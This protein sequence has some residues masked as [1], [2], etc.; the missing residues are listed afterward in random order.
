M[1]N[2]LRIAFT[3]TLV[4]V[5]S[6]GPHAQAQSAKATLPGTDIR[7]W[8]TAD[9]SSKLSLAGFWEPHKGYSTSRENG[10]VGPFWSVARL[11]AAQREGLV[12]NGW[13]VNSSMGSSTGNHIRVRALFLEQQGD[14]TL[15][16]TTSL[17][18][19]DSTTNGSGSVVVADFNGDGM[20]D[21]VFPA[22]NESPFI[23]TASAAWM[24]K[25]GGSLAKIDLP[26]RVEDHDAK[27]VT[28]GGQKR[29]IAK[30][31]SAPSTPIYT[32]SGS[33]FSIDS[34]LEI[35]GMSILAG[36]FTGGS[37]DWLVI[38]DADWG[39]GITYSPQNPMLTYAYKYLLQ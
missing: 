30:S 3:A 11:G 21:V 7:S 39:P 2:G 12:L 36:Q 29:I 26:D 35:G 18:V 28:L 8:A 24:S 4:F 37:D 27:V 20:D 15:L 1:H 13:T 25:P 19:G 14:G 32:W 16:D 33:N 10:L 23:A 34:S 22:H 17:L 5:A 38:G 31:F 9:I 6:F